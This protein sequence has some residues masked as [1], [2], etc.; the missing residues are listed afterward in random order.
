MIIVLCEC[1]ANWLSIQYSLQEN[2]VQESH[3][4]EIHICNIEMLQF[5]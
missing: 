2:S 3:S 5:H 1:E 4:L